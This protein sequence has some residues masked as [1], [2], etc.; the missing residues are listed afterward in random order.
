[1][2]VSGREDGANI[3]ARRA[4]RP[5]IQR[6]SSSSTEVPGAQQ[7][8]AGDQQDLFSP[9]VPLGRRRSGSEPPVLASAPVHSST[10]EPAQFQP[11]TVAPSA[12]A[13]SVDS[14]GVRDDDG[15]LSPASAGMRL[16]SALATAY[17]ETSSMGIAES[18]MPSDL[19]MTVG[20]NDPLAEGAVDEGSDVDEDEAA[21]EDV[22]PAP[23][24]APPVRPGHM[25]QISHHLQRG[26]YNRVSIIHEEERRSSADSNAE[27][28]LEF[29]RMPV[30]GTPA[31]RRP[32]GNGQQVSSLTALLNQHVPH[33]VSTGDGA[34]PPEPAGPA[35]PF[36]SLYATVAAPP[37]VPSLALEIFFPDSDDPSEPIDVSVRKDATVEEVTGHGL[38][39]YWE[40]GRTPMIDNEAE[41]S[42]IAWGLRIVEDDGEVDEDFPR[43]FL[44]ERADNSSRSRVTSVQVFLWAVRYRPRIRVAT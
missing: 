44:D 2:R 29:K 37:T 32:P 1:M 33:L 36:A 4:L 26:A 12:L 35:N 39:K 6:A 17:E 42:T 38:W 31:S 5:Q 16:P 19:A 24:I 15:A 21:D 10:L 9:V 11:A 23:P 22:A 13:V 20:D 27:E 41:L 34:S 43:R 18:A 40:E 8:P 30:H 25:R 7:P 3:R 28:P 14:D